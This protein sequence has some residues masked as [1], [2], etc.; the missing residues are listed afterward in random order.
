MVTRNNH[1]LT[2]IRINSIVK[3][4]IHLIGTTTLFCF[5]YFKIKKE[6]AY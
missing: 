1:M 6:F 4:V 2:K 3:M 5:N